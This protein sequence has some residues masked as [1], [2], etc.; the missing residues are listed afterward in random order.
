MGDFD[1]AEMDYDGL[2]ACFKY[3]SGGMLNRGYDKCEGPAR[4][5]AQQR[6]WGYL[7]T[8]SARVVARVVAVTPLLDC[9]VTVTL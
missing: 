5:P 9:A 2:L 4:R 6:F 8:V 7:T 3:G 1:A